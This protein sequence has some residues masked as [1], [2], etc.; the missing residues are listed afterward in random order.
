MPGL[1]KHLIKQKL[2]AMG[3][4]VLLCVIM[5]MI[6]LIW[7]YL[8]WYPSPLDKAM[9]VSHIYLLMLTIDLVLGPCLTFLVFAPHK[10]SLKFD[11][12]VIGLIQICALL[13]GLYSVFIVRPVW[14]VHNIDHFEVITANRIDKQNIDKAPAAYQYAGWFGPKYVSLA[15]PKDSKVMSALITDN[16][17]RGVIFSERPELYAPI[18]QASFSIARYSNDINT[19]VHHTTPRIYQKIR[20]DYSA[21]DAYKQVEAP[22]KPVIALVSRQQHGKVLGLVDI[23]R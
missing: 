11:L 19:L 23:T 13:Y 12:S 18:E 1:S 4:H 17:K 3:M 22:V 15:L 21:A 6:S 14:I 5:A 9:G 20:Q 10:K 16:I 2:K 7:V 8:V